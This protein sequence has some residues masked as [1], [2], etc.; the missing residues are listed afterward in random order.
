MGLDMYLK[1]ETGKELDHFRKFNAVHGYIV[2]N[3]AGGVDE[4]QL[5]RLDKAAITDVYELLCLVS[6]EPGLAPKLL[7][8]YEGPFFGSYWYDSGYFEHV[9]EAKK[10]FRE[11]LDGF[12]FESGDVIYK[13]SW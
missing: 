8:V 3:Y 6:A 10:A 11:L 4:C 2:G 1:D 12:D 13:A 7:P 5:I 9:V